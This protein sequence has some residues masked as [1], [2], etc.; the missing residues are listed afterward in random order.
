MIGLVLTLDYEIYGD[1]T[2]SIYD[3]IIKPTEDFLS[4]CESCG[5][6]AT[7]FV[8]VAE[9]IRM[10]EYK[11]FVDDILMVEE[12][13]KRAHEKGHDVQLH[14][15][16]W[17]FN[18]KFYHEKWKMDYG[19][20][21]LCNLDAN[22]A[23]RYIRLCK[24]YLSELLKQCDRDYSCIAFRAGSWSMMPTYNIFEALLMA[25]IEIESSVYKWGVMDTEHMK[26]DYSNA[27]NNLHPWFFSRE[28]VNKV[29]KFSTHGRRCLEMPIYAEHQMGIRFLT[30]KRIS[31]MSKVKSAILDNDSSNKQILFGNALLSKFNML[32]RKRAKKL[33]FCKCTFNEMRE[34]IKNVVLCSLPDEYLP[35]VAIG[36]SKDFIF[37]EDL[38]RVLSYL[39][40]KYA[41]II[42]VVPITVASKKYR[43]SPNFL[44]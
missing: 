42:E 43:S 14:I 37:K 12:Q 38:R 11:Y 18:A 13:L 9:L 5:A 27:Y 19:M 29:V 15:H 33:D 26:H 30:K 35:V 44:L 31:L 4:I 28:D 39:K 7:L 10:K 2:G 22:E 16:P 20:S 24:D 40:S 32:V 25:G 3:H 1:G 34:M 21:S 8:E 17:W 41:D 6:K 23:F 36:H